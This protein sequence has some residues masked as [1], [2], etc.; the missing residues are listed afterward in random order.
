MAPRVGDGATIRRGRSD[1]AS[2]ASWRRF[3]GEDGVQKWAF[4]IPVVFMVAF[5]ALP[6]ALTVVWSVFE[7]TQFWMEPGFTLFAYENFFTSA[8]A[9]N[10]YS[11]LSLPVQVR[12]A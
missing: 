8:R 9:E 10:F 11:S 3:L 6:M 1:P 4:Y 5:L 7:R 2:P 12:A